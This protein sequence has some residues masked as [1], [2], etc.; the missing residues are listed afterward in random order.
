M[1]KQAPATLHYKKYRKG[2]NSR[3]K[4]VLR[5][6]VHSKVEKLCGA[7]VSDIHFD[8]VHLLYRLETALWAQRSTNGC[9]YGQISSCIPMGMENIRCMVWWYSRRSRPVGRSLWLPMSKFQHSDHVLCPVFARAN[10]E[11]QTSF[12]RL[13]LKMYKMFV[14]IR[15]QS[16]TGR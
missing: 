16:I 3:S 1:G 14:E 5:Y 8:C 6:H 7:D 11:V 9:R 13:D 12:G 4:G 10:S 15:W 2:P